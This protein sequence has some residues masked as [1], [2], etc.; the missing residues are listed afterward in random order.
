MKNKSYKQAI[1]WAA[2]NCYSK[3]TQN[4]LSFIFGASPEKIKADIEV[5]ICKNEC[6]R[7]LAKRQ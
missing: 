3:S 5:K 6:D 7:Q 2:K 1:A 4:L